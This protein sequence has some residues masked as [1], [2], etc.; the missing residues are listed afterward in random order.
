MPAAKLPDRPALAR[1][2]DA[3]RERREK[4]VALSNFERAR[5]CYERAGLAAEWEDTVGHIRASH[6]RKTGF[7][8]V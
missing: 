4:Q 8:S 6:S 2:R 3:H 1:A 7:L 5:R